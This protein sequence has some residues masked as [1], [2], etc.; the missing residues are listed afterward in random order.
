MPQLVVVGR[1]FSSG[2][3]NVLEYR[4]LHQCLPTPKHQRR[5][6]TALQRMKMKKGR[7]SVI[8]EFIKKSCNII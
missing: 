4:C 8:N 1:P 7:N 5:R 2:F 6:A 3:G